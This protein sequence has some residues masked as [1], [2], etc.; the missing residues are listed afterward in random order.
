VRRPALLFAFLLVSLWAPPPARAEREQ[1]LRGP[2][3]CVPDPTWP[4]R[5]LD[6]VRLED[7]AGLRVANRRRAWGTRLTV[8]RLRQVATAYRLQFPDAAP[9]WIHD[10][11]RPGGGPLRLHH[12]HR[13]GRDV[14]IRLIPRWPSGYVDVTAATLHVRRTWYLILRLIATCD[15]EFIMLDHDLQRVLYGHALRR[16]VPREALGLILQFPY[17]YSH[18]YVYG[19]V[20]RH[21]PRHRNHMH[22][23]FRREDAALET[24]SARALC[25]RPGLNDPRPLID[26]ILADYSI[27]RAVRR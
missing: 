20:V 6:L 13:T 22:V 25:T 11:S 23:R 21:Y 10:I 19:A 8:G 9:L 18:R 5:R 2:A 4:W 3:R 15:V 1:A 17:R 16:R 7:G 12:S 24:Y 14:D 26:R 27:R